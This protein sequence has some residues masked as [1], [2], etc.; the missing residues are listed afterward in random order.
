MCLKETWLQEPI[1]ADNA[2]IHLVREEEVDS[3]CFVCKQ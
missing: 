1:P 2:N 3:L